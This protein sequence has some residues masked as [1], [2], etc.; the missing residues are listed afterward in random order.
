M[1]ALARS[2][3]EGASNSSSSLPRRRQGAF[4][5][6]KSVLSEHPL[7]FPQMTVP[8]LERHDFVPR[9][10]PAPF[11]WDEADRMFRRFW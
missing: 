5:E 8:G 2:A 10:V 6:G 1:D 3:V 7:A 11:P 4:F 9:K